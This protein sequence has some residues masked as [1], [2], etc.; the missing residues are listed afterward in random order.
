MPDAVTAPK[1]TWRA[2]AERTAHAH[3]PRSPRTLC[4]ELVLDERLAW[5][6]PLRR[7]LICRTQEEKL[8][9]VPEGESRAMWGN[10]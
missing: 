1:I 7:C 3:T 2:G 6:D 10:R 4:G 5:P 8:E 9:R